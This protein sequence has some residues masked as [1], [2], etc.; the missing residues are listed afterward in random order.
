MHVIENMLASSRVCGLPRYSYLPACL[1]G[2]S[3]PMAHHIHAWLPSCLPALL[4]AASRS[5]GECFQLFAAIHRITTDHSTIT[6]ITREVLE[7]F[8]ADNVVYVE[9]RTT[10]KASTACLPARPLPAA[11]APPNS[12]CPLV[13]CRP[14]PPHASSAGAVRG[15]HDPG[16]L[17][18]CR[19][20]RHCRVLCCKPAGTGCAGEALV[21]AGSTSPSGAGLEKGQLRVG[22]IPAAR[23]V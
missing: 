13:F 11:C 15:G 7:D 12:P 6:R 17:L 1:P 8:A 18:G 16:L 22:T 19:V 2:L 14:T 3:Q 5:L 21:R 10:P 23:R 20:Q 9:L 4:R